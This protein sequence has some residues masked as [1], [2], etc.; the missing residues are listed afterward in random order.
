[1]KEK[2]R[3][4]KELN[5]QLKETD[6]HTFLRCTHSMSLQEGFLKKTYSPLVECR[7]APVDNIILS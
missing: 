3:K 2:K 7:S 4:G 5:K 6:E 1:M